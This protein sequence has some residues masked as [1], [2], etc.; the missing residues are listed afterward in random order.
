ME[1]DLVYHEAGHAF[2]AAWLGAIVR[3]VSIAPDRDDGP[4]REGEAQIAWR[5][6]RMTPREFAHKQVLVALAGPAA[7]MIYRGE[8]LH[9]G[10]VAEWSADW[11][12]AWRSAAEI[13][14]D[15]R[16]RLVFL[17]EAARLLHERL[18]RDEHWQAIAALAD[19]LSAH[20]I[21][22]GEQVRDALSPWL[23]LDWD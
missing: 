11:R 21:L 22:D 7:E 14:A 9:P 17:E 18:G 12:D 13:H 23:D 15:E 8:P 10:M 6:G 3:H 19:E 2:A 4:R 16:K 1:E 20:E 5:R